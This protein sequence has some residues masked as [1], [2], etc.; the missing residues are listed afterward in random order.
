MLDESVIR[1]A[2]GRDVVD[3]EGK[4][5]GNLE[6]FF[7]DRDDRPAGVARHLFRDVPLAPLPRARAR[8]RARG[9]GGAGHVVEG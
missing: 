2:L 3:R 6:T 7:V 1:E 8:C 4:T 9:G 5:V